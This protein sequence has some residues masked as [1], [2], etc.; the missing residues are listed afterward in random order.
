M[1][2]SRTE[3]M[4]VGLESIFKRPLTEDE[5]DSVIVWDKCRDISN[6]L[7]GFPQEW[8][9]FKEMLEDSVADLKDQWNGLIDKPPSMAENLSVAH[10]QAYGAHAAISGFIRSVEAAPELAKN[11][12]ETV[13]EGY[14][15]LRSM[16]PEK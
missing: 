14:Q 5:K 3:Q 15:Q 6:F 16:P 12:P 1:E 7:T 10:A 4:L 2:V 9:L 8:A 11:V 13:K